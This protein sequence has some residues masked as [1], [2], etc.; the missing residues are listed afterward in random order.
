MINGGKYDGVVGDVNDGAA[1]GEVG[2]DFVFLGARRNAGWEYGHENKGGAKEEVVHGGRVA[3]RPIAGWG[4][5]RNGSRVG[6]DSVK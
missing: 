3:Q 2:D 4:I 6:W 1:T 5:G